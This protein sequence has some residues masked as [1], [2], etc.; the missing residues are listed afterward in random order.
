VRK[1]N[2]RLANYIKANPIEG[3]KMFEDVLNLTMKGMQEDHGKGNSEKQA[4]HTS[5][6]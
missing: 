1:F 5:D 2:P 3:I 4:L 6:I